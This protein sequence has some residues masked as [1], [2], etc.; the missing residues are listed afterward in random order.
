MFAVALGS[1]LE[2]TAVVELAHL[3]SNAVRHAV[4]LCLVVDAMDFML[5]ALLC[6]LP[7][8]VIARPALARR[9]VVG[10]KESEEDAENS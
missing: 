2:P 9:S 8:M 10:E 7:N 6:P 1:S 3:L 4:P 5:T